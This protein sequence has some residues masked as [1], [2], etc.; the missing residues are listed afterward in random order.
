LIGNS[1]IITDLGDP[2]EHALKRELKRELE[3]ERELERERERELEH[4]FTGNF[5]FRYK[6]R[7][8]FK[9]KFT[10]S[11]KSRNPKRKWP[12]KAGCLFFKHV[13]YRRLADGIKTKRL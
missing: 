6:F 4:S 3:L 1:L 7:F 9:F 10:G 11:P 2:C 12:L 5:R 8:K 13:T